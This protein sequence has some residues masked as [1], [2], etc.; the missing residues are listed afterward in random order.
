MIARNSAKVSELI[1]ATAGGLVAALMGLG[2]AV[3]LLDSAKP[4]M[5]AGLVLLGLLGSLPA[6]MIVP[7]MVASWPAGAV[8]AAFWLTLA[9]AFLADAERTA[10]RHGLPF[11]PAH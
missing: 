8:L 6:A 11:D 4:R 7:T 5:I 3:H 2:L 9:A 1:G 10:L